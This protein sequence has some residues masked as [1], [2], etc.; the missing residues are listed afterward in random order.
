MFRRCQHGGERAELGPARAPRTRAR[1]AR[2][3]SSEGNP[4]VSVLANEAK[5][6][7]PQGQEPKA[8]ENWSVNAG[9]SVAFATAAQR[10]TA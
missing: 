10:M 8:E 7:H 3:S 9:P 1:Y 6:S 5:G 4:L 2:C